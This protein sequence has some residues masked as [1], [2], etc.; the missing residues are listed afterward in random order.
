MLLLFGPPGVG[1]T[2]V[3]RRLAYA[4]METQDS[5]HFDWIQC[6]QSYSYE[7]FIQGF[8]PTDNGYFELKNGIF[9]QLCERA[10]HDLSQ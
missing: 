9:Y 3:A 6:H 7:D 5:S 4:L 2:F 10:Q 1:K 8:R